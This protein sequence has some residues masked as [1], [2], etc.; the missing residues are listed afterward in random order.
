MSL[1]LTGVVTSSTTL[2]L[3]AQNRQQALFGKLD[4]DESNGWITWKP[5]V[6]TQEK[7]T[8]LCW[9]PIELRS[10]IF[11]SH[12]GIF[13]VASSSTGQLTVI[14]FAPTLKSLYKSGFIL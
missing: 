14:D 4:F 13:A 5:Y 7:T 11:A 8:K 9:L 12:D 1:D 10:N 2:M 3:S 6:T